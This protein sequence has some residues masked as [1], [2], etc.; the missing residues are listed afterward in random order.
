[1][2][3][4][5]TDQ[6]APKRPAESRIPH[7]RTVAE[8]AEFWDTHS[9]TEFE[10]EFEPV[11]DVRFVVTRGQPKKAITVRLPEAAVAAVTKEAR[12]S[13]IGPSALVRQW[14]LERLRDVEEG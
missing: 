6:P 10:G 8:A 11:Q 7:F 4:P 3:I 2:P 13:G 1:M 12:A 9:T 5:D 14:I